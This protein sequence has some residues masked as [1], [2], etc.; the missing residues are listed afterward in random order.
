MSGR[1][2]EA[3]EWKLMT[4]D[5]AFAG[6]C[7]RVRPNLVG[8]L[9]LHCGDRGVAEEVAQDALART[10]ERWTKVQRM[11]NP[12]AWTYRVAFNLAT[13]WFRRRAAE[14]RARQRDQPV[15]P[16]PRDHAQAV[17]VRAAVAALP[18]RRRTA[19]VLRYYLDLSVADTAEVMGCSPGTVKALCAQ[20]TATLRS[21]PLL[22]EVEGSV[23][24]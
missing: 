9:A 10:W 6:F 18:P 24:G 17:A 23:Y 8:A 4:T 16:A 12:T 3:G 1:R 7:A 19:V 5:D 13:S 14:T 11:P 2:D 20:A 15:E 21:H 22:T